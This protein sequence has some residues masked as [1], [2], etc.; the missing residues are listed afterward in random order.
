MEELLTTIALGVSHIVELMAVVLIALAIGQAS[1]RALATYFHFPP[2][3]P[4]EEIRLHLGKWLTLALEFTVAA[5][6]MRTAVAPSWEAIG[7]LGA[8]I[9]LR[10]VLNFFL[11]REMTLAE[12]RGHDTPASRDLSQG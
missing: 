4:R 12:Q 6:I 5:D 1:F 11:E 3:M 8:I 10:T 9:A 2:Q 7:K